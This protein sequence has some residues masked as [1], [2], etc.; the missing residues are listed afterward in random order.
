MRRDMAEEDVSAYA[1]AE[2]LLVGCP[3]PAVVQRPVSVRAPGCGVGVG[4]RCPV[5]RALRRG[6]WE[7]R[8]WLAYKTSKVGP[9]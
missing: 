7:R 9:A 5:D 8:D 4:A 2:G 1:L 3:A 6:W